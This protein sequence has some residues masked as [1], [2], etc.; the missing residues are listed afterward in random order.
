MYCP[1]CGKEIPEGIGDVRACPFCGATL[2]FRPAPEPRPSGI[3]WED[4]AGLG[5]FG[6]LVAT[7]RMCLTDPTRFYSDLPKRQHLGAALQY[8][9]LLTW[10]GGLGGLFWS[11][12]LR[13]SQ[14]EMLKSFGFN[15]PEQAFSVGARV[16]FTLVFALV[17]PILVVIS[18]FIWTAVVHVLLWILGGAKEGYEATLRVYA[19]A[20]GSTAL[21]E[22]IPFCGGLVA[23]VWGLVLQII[24][25]ARVHGISGAKAALAVLIPLAACC[26]IVVALV[27]AFFTAIMAMLGH[28]GGLS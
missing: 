24:G 16:L 18:T 23:L 8:L 20:R 9:I 28:S 17:I 22:W 15:L 25:L 3:P 11:L 27:A 26:L 21:F 4:R 14:M 10:V 7:L 13:R 5:F 1:G 19:Y 6:A 2:G 12:L